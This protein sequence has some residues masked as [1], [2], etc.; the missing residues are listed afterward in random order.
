MHSVVLEHDGF[1]TFIH[2]QQQLTVRA[3][4]CVV[5]LG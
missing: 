5:R 3:K 1:R 4:R 2:K